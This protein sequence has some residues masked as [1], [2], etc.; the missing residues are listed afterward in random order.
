MSEAENA[1]RK[2]VGLARG[3]GSRRRAHAAL[4]RSA[5]GARSHFAAGLRRAAPGEPQGAPSRPH[6]RH[7]RSQH[8]DD[9]GRALSDQRPDRRTADCHAAQELRSRRHSAVRYRLGPAGHRA[10]DRSGAWPDPAGHDHRLRRQPHQ[11]ARRIRRAGLW[12]RHLG[13][14]A[15]A[16][17]AV[18]VADEAAQHAHLGLRQAARGHDVQGPDSRHHPPARHRWRHGLRDRVRR[19][20]GSRASPWK[21][22]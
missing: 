5:P 18:R 3:A 22:A 6:L 1:V 17:H 4:H 8:P 12:H 21:S 13:S 11:H 15:R 9:L 20:G 2:S 19:R 7:H 16:G 10:R 14:R